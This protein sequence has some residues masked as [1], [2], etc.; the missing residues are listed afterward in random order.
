VVTFDQE[1][2]GVAKG[3]FVS[4]LRVSTKEQGASGLGI[5]AQRQAVLDYLDGGRWTLLAEYV[6]IDFPEQRRRPDFPRV[7]PGLRIIPDPGCSTL[8]PIG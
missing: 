2:L 1:G 4:Y 5:E 3:R 7:P 8:R 6:E